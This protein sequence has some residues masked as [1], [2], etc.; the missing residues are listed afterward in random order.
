MGAELEI[1]FFALI[2]RATAVALFFVYSL[3]AIG[4]VVD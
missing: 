3:H 1:S 4:V 2:E